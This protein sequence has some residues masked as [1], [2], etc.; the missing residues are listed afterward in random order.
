MSQ[1]INTREGCKY[2][3]IAVLLHPSGAPLIDIY[4]AGAQRMLGAVASPPL[5]L[6]LGALPALHRLHPS[7]TALFA[8]AVT[9]DTTSGVTNGAAGAGLQGAHLMHHAH[10][11]TRFTTAGR[12]RAPTALARTDAMRDLVK[13]IRGIRSETAYAPA[14]RRARCR[15]NHRGAASGYHNLLLA[16]AERRD[17]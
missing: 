8:R 1:T 9:G 3:K 7:Q 12:H 13:Q 10:Q 4:Q 6:T 11:C 2:G 16:P 17:K 14:A 5:L 15:Q